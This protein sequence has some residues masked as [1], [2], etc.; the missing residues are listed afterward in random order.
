M[1]LLLLLYALL[2]P[3]KTEPKV[4]FNNWII[5]IIIIIVKIMIV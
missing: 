4:Q 2:K 3:L 5:V 1:Q